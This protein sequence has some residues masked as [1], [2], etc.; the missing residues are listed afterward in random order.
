MLSIISRPLSLSPLLANAPRQAV[1]QPRE[2][3][4]RRRHHPVEP[5]VPIS[6]LGQLDPRLEPGRGSQPLE[7]CRK[8]SVWGFYPVLSGMHVGLSGT[9]TEHL[10]RPGF[11]A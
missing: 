5:Q 7:S 9:F 4:V 11:S 10:T 8:S 6:A 2:F 3:L 1:Y